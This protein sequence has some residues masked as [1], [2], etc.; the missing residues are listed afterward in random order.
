VKFAR[1]TSC[2]AAKL[3]GNAAGDN[4]ERLVLLIEVNERKVACPARIAR[5]AEIDKA[6][7]AALE[8][9]W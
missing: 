5:N 7:V 9:G 3:G 4:F 1:L 6:R 2:V 8:A